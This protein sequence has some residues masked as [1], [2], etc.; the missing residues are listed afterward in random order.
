MDK[1]LAKEIK[2]FCREQGVTYCAVFGSRAKGKPGKGSDLD[3]LIDAKVHGFKLVKLILD[4]EEFLG[5]K[6]DV[7]T[8][9]GLKH[10]R[11]A[12]GKYFK[13]EVEKNLQV[14][15]ENKR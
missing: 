10:P 15:Y 11:G 1:T 9:E 7:I 6:I 14:V 3:L 13:Q 8:R 5:I 4:M 12:A 2:N